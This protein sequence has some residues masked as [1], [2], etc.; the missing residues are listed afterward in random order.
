[1]HIKNRVYVHSYSCVAAGGL[2]CDG[3]LDAIRSHDSPIATD[4]RYAYGQ[5]AAIGLIDN[6]KSFRRNMLD[7]LDEVMVK[8]RLTADNTLL[9]IGSSVG[10][11][12]ISEST[13]FKDGS[14]DNIDPQMH[15]I[16]TLSNMVAQNYNFK[17][18][19]SFSTACTSSANA[20][21]YAHEVIAKGIY[22]DVVVLGADAISHTTVN[23]FAALGVLSGRTCL[24][25]DRE[26][27]GMNV[28]EAVAVLHLSNRCGDKRLCGVGY[29]SDAHHITHPHPEGKGAVKAMRNALDQA[30]IQAADIGYINAHGTGTLANDASEAKAIAKMF[31]KTP[32]S[33]TKSVTGHSLGAAGAL[34]AIITLE[35]L[36]AQLILPNTHLRQPQHQTLHLPTRQYGSRF[37]YAMSNSFAFG[38]NN[39]SL[40]LGLGDE[41]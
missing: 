23:G 36:R 37:Q 38:G 24:P 3:L 33:S 2:S 31:A 22:E 34:E 7:A 21:G 29:S 15:H 25:F 6:E 27:T 10:G 17:R 8:D 9:V 20:L 5:K 12:Y 4:T 16:Q 19:I 28:S 32:V 11:I 30:G 13:F 26:R 39:T 1:M 41:S 40:V 14:Y 18:S 35:A